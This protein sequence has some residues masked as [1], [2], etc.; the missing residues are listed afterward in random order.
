MSDEALVQQAL[1]VYHRY[2]LE[3]VE[4]LN[5]CPWAVHARVAGRVAERVLLQRDHSH[6]PS[7]QVIRELEAQPK[8]EI[9]LL[10]FPRLKLNLSGFERF[11]AELRE[12]DTTQ[13]PLGGVPFASAAF[14]PEARRT[15]DTPERLVQYIRRTPDPTIQLVRRSVLDKVRRGPG[16]G[17][18]F[19]DLNT[20]SLADLPKPPKPLREVVAATNAE[21]LIEHGFS[22]FDALIEDIRRDRDGSY[23]AL[24]E[25]SGQGESVSP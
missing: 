11:V 7:M 15:S 2:Q 1:R 19:V 4:A 22:R 16:D 14:H 23:A 18:Q 20:V 3:V 13:W 8:F 5:L 6:R 21:T 25:A 9:G 24:G 17:T 12:A 10:I